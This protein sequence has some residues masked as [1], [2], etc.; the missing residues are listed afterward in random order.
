LQNFEYVMA[1]SVSEVVSLLA[2][3]GNEARILAGGTDLLVQLREGRKKAGLVIDIKRVPEANELKYDPAGGLLLGAAVPC[4]R[5]WSEPEIAQA[6]PGLIDAISLIGGMQIQ[7]RA[8]VGGNLCN[9]S[10]AADAIP[11]L[12]VHQAVCQIAGPGGIRELPVEQFCV[13]PGK[14]VLRPDEFLV[15]LRI[16]PVG[17]TFGAGYLRFIPRNEMDIAVVGAGAAV[18]LDDDRQRF[19]A[20]RV[21]LGA[22]APTPLLV[23]EAGEFLAGK[24][25]TAENVFEA[26]RMAQSAARPISDM[27]GAAD[28][29]KHLALVLVK[30]VLN[31]AIERAREKVLSEK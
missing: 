24:D 14:N 23:A 28:Q 19:S 26:A 1:Q 15:S 11:A 8:S 30:R 17:E 10:P 6:Y 21:A 22:V 9:A 12:I 16:P 4:C 2:Q 3:R 18:T 25:V 20:A 5:V 27:R 31:I 7:G 29:R 13:A